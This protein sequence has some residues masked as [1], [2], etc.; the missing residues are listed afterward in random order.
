MIDLFLT[1]SPPFQCLSFIFAMQEF[2]RELISLTVATSRIYVAERPENSRRWLA[3]ISAALSVVFCCCLG[4]RVK[5]SVSESQS[6]QSDT[7]APSKPVRR[8]LHRRICMLLFSFWSIP[9]EII[10]VVGD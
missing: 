4:T 7:S 3:R 6:R 8:G 1:C 10:A 2:A 5:S 9:P